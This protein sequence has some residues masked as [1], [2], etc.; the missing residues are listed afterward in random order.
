MFR[1]DSRISLAETACSG[2]SGLEEDPI[3]CPC[4]DFFLGR[5]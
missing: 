4:P 2:L 1:L 3:L 5:E